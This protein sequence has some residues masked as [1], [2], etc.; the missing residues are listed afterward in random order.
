[1]GRLREF[2]EKFD[3]AVAERGGRDADF[4]HGFNDLGIDTSHDTM[5]PPHGIPA[6]EI[7]PIAEQTVVY[8]ASDLLYRQ[9]VADH[10][11]GRAADD[12]HRNNTVLPNDDASSGA[13]E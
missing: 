12:F 9:A 7:E 8:D 6:V 4:E 11:A 2:I 1:M 5:T 13:V 10:L 3:E